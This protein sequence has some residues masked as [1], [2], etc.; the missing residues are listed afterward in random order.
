VETLTT[1]I[2]PMETIVMQLSVKHGRIPELVRSRQQP[3]TLGRALDNDAVVSDPYVAPH[4]LRFEKEADQWFAQVLDKHNPVLLNGE[5]IG[6]ER[7]QLKSGDRMTIGRT[8]INIYAAN[9][10]VEDTRKL[11]LSNS[12]F[13]GKLG[14]FIAFAVLV[15]VTA[16]DGFV[17]FIQLSVTGQWQQYVDSALM[18]GLTVIIWA[19]FWSIM[20]RLFRHH[21]QFSLQLLATSLLMCA[22]VFL[23]PLPAYL[24]YLTSSLRVSEVSGYLL[25][26]IF[27]TSLLRYNLVLATHVE[28]SWRVAAGL[29]I[30]IIGFTYLISNLENDGFSYSAEYSKVLKPPFAARSTAK[31]LDEYFDA[32][33]KNVDWQAMEEQ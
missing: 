31:N 21:Q 8:H 11:M 30:A 26:F 2:A 9:H 17:D 24:E 19:G 33:N 5:A 4:L 1:D 14:L 7:I 27:I 22:L 12:L 20:G 23:A 18:G 10:A 13:Q 29:S 3:I 15:M 16:L 6:E 32:L 28:N 25:A